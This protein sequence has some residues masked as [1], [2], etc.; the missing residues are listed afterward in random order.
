MPAPYCTR[1]GQAMLQDVRD[2][3]IHDPRAAELIIIEYKGG[4]TFPFLTMNQE[5]L[6]AFNQFLRERGV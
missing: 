5:A 2:W 6:A 1:K 3:I 4:D